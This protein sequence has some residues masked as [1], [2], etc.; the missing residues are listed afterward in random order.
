MN[1]IEKLV[2]DISEENFK[3]FLQNKF[4]NFEYNKIDI[5][6][7]NLEKYS[8]SYHIGSAE[9]EDNSL[10]FILSKVKD[11]L[12]EKS[13]KKNQYEFIKTYLKIENKDS[14]IAIFYDENKNFR[15]SFIKANYKGKK[16]EF[17]SF[18]RYTYFISQTQSN[19]TFIEQVGKCKFDSLDNILEAFSIQPLNK[20]FYNQIYKF[21]DKLW[22]TI[23]LGSNK[24]EVKKN[25]AIRLIGRLIFCWF[26]QKKT[27]SKGNSLIPAEW[28]SIETIKQLENQ[29][30]YKIYLEKLFFEI[31]NKKKNEREDKLPSGSEQIPYLNGGLFDALDDDFTDFQEDKIENSYFIDLYKTFNQYNFTIDENSLDDTEVSI[32]PEMLGTIFENLLAEINPETADSVRKQTGSFY[33]PREI[34]DFMI[35]NALI[36]HLYSKTKIKKEKIKEVFHLELSKK[37]VLKETEKD[38]ILK[39]LKETKIFDPACG[40]GAFP[41]GMLHK[42]MFL[43]EVLDKDATW[44]FENQLKNIES[45]S[46]KRKLKAEYEN[47]NFD[48]IRKIDVF[49]NCIY[50]SDIQPLAS[51]ITKLR[52]FLSL[53]I[54]E[55]IDDTKE[56]RGIEPLPNLEFKFIT[57]N[58]LIELDEGKEGELISKEEKQILEDLE[59][60]RGDYLNA[61][62]REKLDLKQKFEN[63]QETLIKKHLKISLKDLRSMSFSSQDKFIS[64]RAVQIGRWQPFRNKVCDWFDSK[65]MFGVEKFDIVIG[66]PPYVQL[67]KNGGELGNKY[68]DFKFETFVKSGDIY[69]LFYE[70]GCNLL[71]KEGFLCY[72]TSNKWMRAGYGKNLRNYLV[73]KTNPKILVDLGPGVF[74]SAT[75]D[76][77]ILLFQNG[78]KKRS[79]NLEVLSLKESLKSIK[80]TL[81]EY[82]EKEKNTMPVPNKDDSWV[83]LSKLE[84]SIKE[85]IEEV[86]TP[87]KDWDVSIN[88]GITTGYNEAF[89]ISTEKREEILKNCKDKEEREKTKELIKPIL[90]G[91]DIKKYQ[92]EWKNLW[93]LYIHTG[94]TNIDNYDSIK[95]HL[96]QYKNNLEKK[97]GSCQWYQIQ[98]DYYKSGTYKNFEKEKIAWQRITQEPTF[99]IGKNNMFILV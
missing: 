81:R 5:L 41:M 16:R 62:G 25:F 90:R 59:S 56:N 35:E 3:I 48:Y 46:L 45:V 4:D 80:I 42:I 14:A 27:D 8:S 21:Y 93:L 51:E 76:S 54:D 64:K 22:Q 37:E 1:F 12:T 53:V 88:R 65:F 31:L 50:G 91:R 77:N 47:R 23:N 52:C 44:W 6:E 61:N 2:N 87:L 24:E 85:K 92:S 71:S 98:A 39:V 82:F 32:D 79:D 83:I 89:I 70:K 49:Y 13:S 63:L 40:S 7:D 75:V 33:T 74:E 29:N 97:Q 99:C 55:R 86:G 60:V 19:K 34:V 72:I 26:L 94:I 20:E 18:K 66:N 11:T 9:L 43:Y 58:T 96:L 38:K 30:Y 28:F 17:T 73:E 68:K 69:A 78:I 95:N 15:F 36:E 57:T 84:F 10:V 67:Q